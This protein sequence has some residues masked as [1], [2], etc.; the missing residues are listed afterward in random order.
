MRNTKVAN[1]MTVGAP[2]IAK[3]WRG[4]WARVIP[5]FAYAPEIRKVI[6]T[7]NARS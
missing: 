2:R 5:F 1:D 4:N 6:Y 3:S 7:T